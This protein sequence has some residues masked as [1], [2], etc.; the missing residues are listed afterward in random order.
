MSVY[1]WQGIKDSEQ[2]CSMAFINHHRME[3]QREERRRGGV[4]KVVTS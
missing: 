4:K 2:G 1:T 3:Q